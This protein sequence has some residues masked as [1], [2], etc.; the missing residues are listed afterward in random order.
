MIPEIY[1]NRIPEIKT[2]AYTQAWMRFQMD[3][4]YKQLGTT[5]KRKECK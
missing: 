4:P 3:R 1:I 5:L 2:H